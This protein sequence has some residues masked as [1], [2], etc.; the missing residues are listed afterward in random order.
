MH[1]LKQSSGRKGKEP[2][3]PRCELLCLVKGIE[4]LIPQLT[5]T[6]LQSSPQEKLLSGI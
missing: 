2:I 6:N 5:T 3:T 1:T 4:T